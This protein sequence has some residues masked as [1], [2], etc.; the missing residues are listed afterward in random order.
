[1]MIWANRP[2]ILKYLAYK[3]LDFSTIQ[4]STD[5]IKTTTGIYLEGIEM[6][7]ESC[8]LTRRVAQMFQP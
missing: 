5:N 8:V 4:Y 3:F 2:L 6:V 7:S 1:M